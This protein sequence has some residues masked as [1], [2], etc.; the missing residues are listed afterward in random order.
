M[1]WLEQAKDYLNPDDVQVVVYHKGCQDG[2][3]AALC[4]WRKIGDG[5]NVFPITYIP[6]HYHDTIT[7][8]DYRNKNV[9]L[10]DFSWM[11]HELEDVRKVANKVLILDHH[12]SAMGELKN[13]EGC[14]F[15]MEE[16]GATMA[17]KYFASS[18]EELNNIPRF[19][20]YVKD[21]DLWK[22]EYIDYSQPMYYG[23]KDLYHNS[24][25]NY[26][27]YLQT[28]NLEDLI[29]HGRQVMDEQNKWIAQKASEAK[30]RLITM[31]NGKVYNV[32]MLE[33]DK[34][35]LISEISAYLYEHN[36]VHFTMC[37]FRNEGNTQ[38]KWTENLWSPLYNLAHWWYQ[39]KASNASNANEVSSEASNS[40]KYHVSLRT[41]RFKFDVSEIAKLYGGGGHE[42]AAGFTLDKNPKYIF[43]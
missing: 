24:F 22:W 6:M 33:L 16:S 17:W 41:N 40:Q 21:R 11:K 26:E 32:M 31:C 39:R 19:I 7:L 8:R 18:E 43:N 37:W 30:Q 4:A 42:Q 28:E 38:P 15:D 10:L 23:I 29:I 3:T 13:I 5:T 25:R 12:K 9:L 36:D 34:S 27:K 2:M 35:K 1:S 20:K 14:F